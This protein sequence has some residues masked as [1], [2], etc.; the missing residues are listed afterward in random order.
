[1]PVAIVTDSTADLSPAEAAALN[2]TVVPLTVT[3]GSDSYLDRVEMGPEEFYRRL[4]SSK[5]LPK[6][7]QPA[8]ARFLEAY[9]QLLARPDVTGI[10][11]IHISSKLSGTLNAA[12]T[13]RDQLPDPSQVILLDSLAVTAL[14]AMG[15]RCA[16]LAAAGGATAE[17]CS[18]AAE[19]GI[20]RSKLYGALDTLEYLQK[21]GRIGRARALIG[22][23]L[24][25]KPIITFRDGEVSPVERVRSHGK[26][27]ER[28][29]EL[30]LAHTNA[31]QVAILH[32]GPSGDVERVRQRVNAAMPGVSISTGWL[33]P[34]VGVYGGPNVVGTVV[35]D[36]PGSR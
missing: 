6:T 35:M 36:K 5:V 12:R 4:V 13:A 11:S 31:E 20:A 19:N 25:L 21:G 23:M 24:S 17:Q 9:E 22:T 26:A 18:A 1:M 16:S 27:V 28:I 34:V 7:S 30:T 32:S 14:L 8:P 33:G 29:I 15:V 3:I 2:V 10:L